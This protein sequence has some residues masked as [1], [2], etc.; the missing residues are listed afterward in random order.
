[1]LPMEREML[2]FESVVLNCVCNLR[3]K[4]S[5]SYKLQRCSLKKE[6]LLN[7]CFKDCKLYH[8]HLVGTDQLYHIIG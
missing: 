3:V 1:M 8:L 4:N 2:Y 7:N 6:T 5:Q